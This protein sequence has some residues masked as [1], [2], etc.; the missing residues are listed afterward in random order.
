MVLRVTGITK[1]IDSLHISFS[2]CVSLFVA[3]EIF[4]YFLK[5]SLK[6]IPSFDFVILNA[7]KVY[8]L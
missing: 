4:A 7:M 5:V 3:G 8:F 6:I 1:D 2:C